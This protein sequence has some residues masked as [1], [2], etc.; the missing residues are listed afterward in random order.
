MYNCPF[1]NKREQIVALDVVSFLVP[2]FWRQLQD[3]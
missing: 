1:V 2:R 3:L